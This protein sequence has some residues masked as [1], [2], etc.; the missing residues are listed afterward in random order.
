VPICVTNYVNQCMFVVVIAKCSHFSGHRVFSSAYYSMY[1][2]GL[3]CYLMSTRKLCYRKDVRAMHN[4]TIRT[5][6]EARKSTS[7]I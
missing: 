6:F 2:L 7:I 3:M 1:H 5:W 4:P